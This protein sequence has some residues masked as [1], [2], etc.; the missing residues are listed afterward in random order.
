MRMLITLVVAL[1]LV[2]PLPARAQYALLVRPDAEALIEIDGRPV[3]A[4]PVRA[5]RSTRFPSNR[6]ST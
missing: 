5:G 4:V 3:T 6:A 1:L 2:S